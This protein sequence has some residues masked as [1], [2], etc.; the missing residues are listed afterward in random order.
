[1]KNF[2]R[3]ICCLFIFCISCKSENKKEIEVT[4]QKEIKDGYHLLMMKVENISSTPIY[5]PGLAL[6]GAI[7]NKELIILDSEKKIINDDFLTN[8][9]IYNRKL[10]RMY[11]NRKFVTDFCSD[12]MIILDDIDLDRPPF[13]EKKDMVR[14]I[15]QREYE[16]LISGKQFLALTEEDIQNIKSIIFIKYYNAIFLKPGE[17]YHYCYTINSLY[18]SDEI[19][20]VFFQYNFPEKYYEGS[21]SFYYVFK[22]KKDSVLLTP[23]FLPE[24]KGYYLYD[25]P[26]TSDTLVIN[27]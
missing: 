1:M 15:I 13:N 17:I 9:S 8:E 4:L 11:N 16:T 27:P 5:I 26:F 20:K 10:N 14:S 19:H 7:L 6:W 12:N 18:E 22:Y 21:E 24:F 23:Y 25:Q 3:I 2:I